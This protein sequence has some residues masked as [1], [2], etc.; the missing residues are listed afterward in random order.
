MPFTTHII[1]KINNILKAKSCDKSLETAIHVT[2]IAMLAL[3]TNL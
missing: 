2:I 1:T 3:C